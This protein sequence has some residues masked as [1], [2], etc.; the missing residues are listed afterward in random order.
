MITIFFNFLLNNRNYFWLMM[1]TIDVES[2]CVLLVLTKEYE[3]MFLLIYTQHGKLILLSSSKPNEAQLCISP[4][5]FCC[6]RLQ[7]L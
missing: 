7:Q 4:H 2:W 1:L 5:L 6:K 3:Y